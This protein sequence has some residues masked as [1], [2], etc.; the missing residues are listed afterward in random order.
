MSTLIYDDLELRL[1]ILAYSEVLNS[2]FGTKT[3]LCI[4]TNRRSGKFVILQRSPDPVK[5]PYVHL[6]IEG[7][8]NDDS[9]VESEPGA[10]RESSLINTDSFEEFNREQLISIEG[11]GGTG[12]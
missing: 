10:C 8:M 5:P 1:R 9:S 12:E 11:G 7:T 6:E 2:N 4:K 3:T